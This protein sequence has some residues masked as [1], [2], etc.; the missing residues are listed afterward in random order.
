MQQPLILLE[1]NEINFD[2]AKLYIESGEKLD[3]FKRA[4]DGNLI[5]TRSEEIY[6]NLEP[7]IQ[8]PSVHTGLSFQDH[9]IFRLGDIEK[10]YKKQIFEHIEQKGFL[11]GAISPMNA[12]NCLSNPAYFIPDPWTKTPTDGYWLSNI[13]YKSVAQSVNDNSEGKISL[14][15]L[16]FLI[17]ASIFCVRFKKLV[18]LSFYAL[19]CIKL[20]YRKA[21]F[22]DK[23]LFEFHRYF[24]ER[25]KPDFATIFLNGG[26]HIQH[27]YFFNSKIFK[28][29]QK[30]PDWY[31]NKEADPVLDMLKVYDEILDELINN[32]NFELIVAT[33]L[34][35]EPYQNKEFYYRPK[36][37]KRLFYELEISFKDIEPR[38]TRDFL[39]SFDSEKDTE[40]AKKIL[41][42][43]KVNDGVPLF[44]EIEKRENELFISLTYS[45]EIDN[46]TFV[47]L[48]QKRIFL[49]DYVVFVALKNGMHNSKGFAYFSEGVS[50]FAPK[51]NSH[52]KNL[53]NTI[54]SFF[55]SSL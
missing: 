10:K 4:F 36:N 51:Q 38:M 9:E 27:H 21:L 29:I 26:A 39:V 46:R 12:S 48:N 2:V 53:F 3:G 43:L 14:K 33:G 50:E 44:N 52:V 40:D 30:N 47:E 34:T 41:S 13:I 20:K 25:K 23:L 15:S 7:W 19:S 35:Q 32:K 54:N 16:I 18:S 6:E 22:L 11:V 55:E 1:L 49:K 5:V 31:L 37:H 24:F 45:N 28:S 42:Q 17:S 8:W